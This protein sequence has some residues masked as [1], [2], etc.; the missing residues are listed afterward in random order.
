LRVISKDELYQGYLENVYQN[1]QGYLSYSTEE[2]QRL[3]EKG[4]CITYGELLYFGVEKI[5]KN[6]K[7]NKNTIFLDLGCGLGKTALQIFMKTD[8]GKVIGIEAAKPLTDEALIVIESVKSEFPLFWE[9]NR[10]LELKCDNFLQ[11][12]WQNATIIYTCSTC[13]TQELLVAIG[14][15]IN[16]ERQVEQVFSLRPLPT[17]QL[18]LKKVFGVECSW[19][20]SL[21]FYYSLL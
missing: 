2:S 15:K 19:D 16:Q 9:N 5:L 11:A 3:A 17:I 12:S 1:T 8:I 13:F 7:I 14:D 4:I 18:P 20:S 6:L 10:T 21:C